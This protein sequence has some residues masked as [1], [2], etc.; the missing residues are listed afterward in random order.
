M[1]LPVFWVSFINADDTKSILTWNFDST[2]LEAEEKKKLGHC[3]LL[4]PTIYRFGIGKWN[5]CFII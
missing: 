4:L 1:E 3:I 2:Q 5:M